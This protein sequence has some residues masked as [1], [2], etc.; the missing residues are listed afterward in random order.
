[1]FNLPERV[2]AFE[3]IKFLHSHLVLMEPQIYKLI[4][5]KNSISAVEEHFAT[6]KPVIPEISQF[7]F[8]SFIPSIIRVLIR[9]FSHLILL[10]R[11]DQI[12]YY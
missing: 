3:S 8:N 6:Y 7:I 12:I 4:A 1:M 10:Q 9:L 5:D 11:D 2:V